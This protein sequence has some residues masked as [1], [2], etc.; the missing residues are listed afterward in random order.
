M[1]LGV[2]VNAG[3]RNDP[4]HAKGIAHFTEHMLFKGTKRRSA[5]QIA[6]EIDALGG[7]L[8]AQTAK[9]YT[10]YYT[11]VLDEHVS[12]ACD[13]LFD[14][15]LNA[16]V[17]PEE[18]EKEKKVVLQ[19]IR[20]TEDN[21]E[22]YITDLFSETFFADTTLGASILG[23]MEHVGCFERASVMDFID[24][25]YSPSSI[26]VAAAGNLDH[27]DLVAEST[28]LFEAMPARDGRYDMAF[29]DR[30]RPLKRAVYRDIEQVHFTLG[31][32]GSAMSDER[33]WAY[34]VLNTILGA[35]MSSLLFQEAREKRG[36][37]YSIYSYISAYRDCGVLAVSAACTPENV[38]ETLDVIRT[39]FTRLAS[40]DAGDVRLED[41]K[42]QIKGNI[43]LARE[44]SVNRM[45]AMAKN[46]IYYGREVTVEE[47]LEKIN[48]VSMDD[49]VS[50]AGEIFRE[51]GLTL[52]TLGRMR[53][54]DISWPDVPRGAHP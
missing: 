33:R 45:T 9:E 22:D 38:N 41:V 3:S 15:F 49:V 19:E 44:S 53:A 37:V 36:L 21:P 14:L 10:V 4:P 28:A 8:N 35:S 52:V 13:I 47:V 12:K 23:T 51:Q 50:L 54:E 27:D 30:P 48:A 17:N 5:L 26:I 29:T 32:R 31:T 20:M 11:K 39:Q 7:H 16:E 40:G 1:S 2:W 18:L 24:S 34:I 43:L 25:A 6:K 46:E 42:A